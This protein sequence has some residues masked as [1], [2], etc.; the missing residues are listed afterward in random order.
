MSPIWK[1][2]FHVLALVFSAILA[3][4][5]HAAPQQGIAMYGDPALPS[6]FTHLPYANPSAPRGGQIRFG[7]SG[8]FD[9]LNPW[10]LNGRPAQ[11]IALYVAESLMARSIDEPFTLYGLLAESIETDDARSWVEFTLRPGA[12]FSDGNPVTVEDVIWSYETLGTQGHPRYQTAW[13]KVAKIEQTGPR[14]LRI[15][16]TEPDRELALLMGMRPV[17]EKAQ[18]QGRDFSADTQTVPIGSGPY[19][20]SRIDMG[21]FIELK[22]NPNWWGKDLPVNV[23]RYNIDTMRWDYFGDG[24]VVFEAFKGGE[25]DTFRETNA[26]KW[27]RD[28]D[29]PAVRDGRVVKEDIP[30]H[31]PSGIAGLV[32]NTRLPVFQD[33]R[34]REAMTLAFN[35]EFISRTLTG[36]AEPRITSYFANSDLAMRPG[37]AEGR[38]A[39]LLDPFRAELPPGTIEGY[40]L[41]VSDGTPLNRANN[42]KAIRLLEDAGWQVDGAG[43]LRNGAGVPLTFEIV[44]PQGASETRAIVDIYT[45]ALRRLGIVPR[46]TTVDDAQFQ[47]RKNSYDFGMTWMVLSLSLSPGNEQMLYWGSR[48]VTEP[49]SRNLMGMASPA[50]EAMIRAMLEAESSEDFTAAVQALDRILTAGRYVIPIWYAPISRIAHIRELHFPERLPLYGDW[51]GFQ[52]E[53]W[54]Y[55]AEQQQ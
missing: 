4:A 25:I 29:F 54:W 43:I 8:S 16:F 47:M 26:A 12:R 33:W 50:A 21:R 37:P 11:G 19:T 41:P 32:M 31:R 2:G 40:A 14:S 17:L 48:G 46:V 9:S 35:F 39:A 28:Y 10:I 45:E 20:V 52:P 38:V 22:R 13:R 49:G 53:V 24:G 36:G 27:A 6:G 15:T 1:H 23:G 51:P 44:L 34:V 42:R 55:E 30:H 7:E 3:P 18:W 5:V